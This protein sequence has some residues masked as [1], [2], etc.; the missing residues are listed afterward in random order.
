[1]STFGRN[2][3]STVDGASGRLRDRHLVL[4]RLVAD[5]SVLG[6]VRGELAGFARDTMLDEDGTADFLLATYEAVAN[7]VEHAYPPGVVGTFDLS[8][9]YVD[10]T[11]TVIATIVDHGRW[12]PL[13]DVTSTRRG[14]GLRLLRACSDAVHVESDDDGTRI[15]LQWTRPDGPLPDEERQDPPVTQIESPQDAAPAAGSDPLPVVLTVPAAHS[16]LSVIRLLSEMVAMNSGCTLDQATD[17]KLAVD[18]LCT[19]MIDA[20]QPGSTITCRYEQQGPLFR[21]TVAATTHAPWRP[22]AD[23]LEWRIL[24]SL[25]DELTLDDGA[26]EAAAVTES[27]AVLC[28]TKPVSG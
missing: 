12:Q 18:Q 6:W 19:L 23:S 7:V 16:Q 27:T 9:H 22:A 24:E 5:P 25:A 8:A 21:V 28:M 13:S 10:T 4:D 15:Q 14:N 11:A 1:M 17:L 2:G 26:V 20:A 3:S